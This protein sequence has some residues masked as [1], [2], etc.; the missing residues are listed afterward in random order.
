MFI[1]SFAKRPIIENSQRISATVFVRNFYL[2]LIRKVPAGKRDKHGLTKE[3]FVKD[4][5]KKVES[6]STIN[7]KQEV[8]G[9]IEFTEQNKVK[10]TYTRSNL[11]KGFIFWFICEVCGRKVRYLYIPPNSQ[12]SACRACHRLAY[13]C[14]NDNKRSRGLNRLLN[15]PTP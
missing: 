3:E 9:K 5:I 8:N 14:Q 10:M 1:N 12:V 6:E 11:G 15:N 4:L 2:E 7:L 13:D